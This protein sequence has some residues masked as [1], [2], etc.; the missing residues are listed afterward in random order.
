[1]AL[2]LLAS[3]EDFFEWYALGV[4]KKLRITG[5]YEAYLMSMDAKSVQEVPQIIQMYFKYNNQLG[6]SPR[7]FH[8]AGSLHSP[9][10]GNI[11]SAAKEP[12]SDKKA[13]PET[14]IAAAGGFP[15]E[16]SCDGEVC[17]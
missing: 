1:M 12:S 2:Y 8:R 17:I 3:G 4:E 13:V 5:L 14:R 15:P 11:P 7:V 10:D 9:S 16:L 6:I